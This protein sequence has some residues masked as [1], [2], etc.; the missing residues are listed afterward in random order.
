MPNAD[1]LP[2][3]LASSVSLAT[4]ASGSI[5]ESTTVTSA[6]STNATAIK[7]SPG[8]LYEI[9]MTNYA[10]A[11]KF[12]KL[13]NK[14]SAP[15]VGTDVPVLTISLAA[16]SEKVYAFG[17][18]GKRFPLGIALAITNLQPVADVTVV[19]AGDVVASLSWA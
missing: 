12:V 9:S 19:A 13:Y 5:L 7:A 8:D 4:G 2:A 6:A 10:A 11:A 17:D 1:V 14:A 15:T 16:N 18:Q 3:P